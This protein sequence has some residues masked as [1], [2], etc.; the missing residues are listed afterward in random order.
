VK[1][2]IAAAEKLD[3]LLQIAEAEDFGELSDQLQILNSM[4]A[5]MQKAVLEPLLE[6]LE[7]IERRVDACMNAIHDGVESN[8]DVRSSNEDPSEHPAEGSYTSGD[9]DASIIPAE[10]IDSEDGEVPID[11]QK[12]FDKL[13]H[14][15]DFQRIAEEKISI[16]DPSEKIAGIK[17]KP[18]SKGIQEKDG[19]FK[20]G[21]RQQ[22]LNGDP[23]KN[24]AD[25]YAAAE[26]AKPAFKEVVNAILRG[27]PDLTES[28]IEIAEMKDSAR[29]S[30]K[31]QEEYTYRIPG[32][33]EA[34]LYD[35][36]RASV[37]CKT[38][39]QLTEMN[40]WLKEN[41]H[42][43]ACE[44]RFALPQFDGYRDILYY[45]SVPYK[46][47]LA[48]VCEIQVHHKD[49]K[50]QFGENSHRA[51]FRPYFAGPWREP[52]ENLRDLEMLLQVGRI[53]NN[54]VEFLLE[55]TDSSQ[56]KLF[57][58]IFFE[59]L[60]ETDRAL[61]LFKRVLTM[62]ESSLGKG[63]V[64]S[65]TTYQYI[66]LAL[67]KKGDSDGSLL[68]LREA[69][70]VSEANLG[71]SHPE[72]ATIR[73]QIGDA[74]LAKGDYGKALLEQDESLS[75]R[76]EAL[77]ENHPLVAESYLKVAQALREK[78]DYRKALA[79]CRTALT[80]QESFFGDTN[81]ELAQTYTLMGNILGKQGED[82]KA[83][84][85]FGSAHSI[86][87][88]KYG[89]K[90]QRVADSLCDIGA[91]KLKQGLYEEAESC[92]RRSL[93]IRE[94]I[95]G[96]DGISSRPQDQRPSPGSAASFDFQFL[97]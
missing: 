69:L 42:I 53:D 28:D 46:E 59:N 76:E 41:V 81:V 12:F 94:T 65:A 40:K 87:E 44:N 29:A 77:G 86:L 80:I 51:H 89:K 95:L 57:G 60:E 45:V 1:A 9:E 36:L 48:F 91:I 71:S 54:L 33:R 30:Q 78:G 47:E 7:T 61:E 35:I 13:H 8:S 37:S 17:V 3:A 24:L 26:E 10:V 90:H 74:L 92:H 66:G 23:V 97:L 58:R 34:W 5:N 56:I 16:I 63:H 67:L 52:F 64:I 85:M 84:E 73:S 27:V 75:I 31:A 96:K 49:F 6:S 15:F 11:Q 21:Y 83:I 93:E 14:F 62:E 43:V 82:Q 20:A 4:V 50:A 55:A 79:E 70:A 68:Y 72:L 32:P 25:L 19:T 88:N 39:R 22:N 38:Y 2:G 18:H